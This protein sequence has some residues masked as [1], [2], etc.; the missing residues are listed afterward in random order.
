MLS[1]RLIFLSSSSFPIFPPTPPTPPSLTHN[2]SLP[3]PANLYEATFASGDSGNFTG[4]VVQ[5]FCR[6]DALV[7]S[8]GAPLETTTDVIWPAGAMLQFQAFVGRCDETDTVGAAKL[9]IEYSSGATW[10][11]V[12]MNRSEVGICRPEHSWLARPHRLHF[13]TCHSFK[14]IVCEL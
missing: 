10:K 11:M 8:S 1:A 7:S 3:A 6:R 9:V 5:T 14:F 2:L 4:G 12:R 13:V